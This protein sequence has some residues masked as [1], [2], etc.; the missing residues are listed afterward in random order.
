MRLPNL[1]V[2]I[3][4][5]MKPPNAADAMFRKRSVLGVMDCKWEGVND[6]IV[7]QTRAIPK[8]NIKYPPL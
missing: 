2:I 5:K 4:K 3:W 1:Y 8:D 6:K 7:P